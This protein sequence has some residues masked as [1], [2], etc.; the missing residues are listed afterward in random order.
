MPNTTT[1]NVAETSTLVAIPKATAEA[2]KDAYE[3]KDSALA[4]SILILDALSEI[5]RVELRAK[6]SGDPR[7][8]WAEAQETARIR[9]QV[10]ETVNPETFA[11]LREHG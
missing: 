9:E 11:R 8:T 1:V 2:R 5:T 7:A 3:I 6:L 4:L 10:L